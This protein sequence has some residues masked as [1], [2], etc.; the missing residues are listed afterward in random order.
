MSSEIID[1]TPAYNKIYSNDKP[2][3]DHYCDVGGTL[4][5]SVQIF[6]DNGERLKLIW[7]KSKPYE[8]HRW[9]VGDGV[10]KMGN[11]TLSEYDLKIKR[12]QSEVIAFAVHKSSGFEYQYSSLQNKPIFYFN[13]TGN[14]KYF[15]PRGI[16]SIKG[17]ANKINVNGTN[18]FDED[19]T[20]I[21]YIKPFNA[22]NIKGA[23][24]LSKITDNIIPAILT[25]PTLAEE[26]NNGIA[27]KQGEAVFVDE[28]R[29]KQGLPW[30]FGNV[31]SSGSFSVSDYLIDRE[32]YEI[33]GTEQGDN[34][35]CTLLRTIEPYC[36]TDSAEHY[37]GEQGTFNKISGMFTPLS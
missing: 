19:V 24:Q 15:T 3:I 37:K 6:A 33:S 21:T 11:I 17:I 7:E 14:K 2:M 28:A 35:P 1:T 20:E 25:R 34:I 30:V 13:R 9:L 10:A 31:D 36:S 4:H 8:E 18:I 12:I 29:Y 5:R 16:D 27:R 22:Y 23:Y 26:D 32:D